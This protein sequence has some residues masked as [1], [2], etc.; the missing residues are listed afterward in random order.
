MVVVECPLETGIRTRDAFMK[1]ITGHQSNV[2]STAASK[3][4]KNASKWKCASEHTTCQSSSH[5]WKLRIPMQLL[6]RPTPTQQTI[7]QEYTVSPW[8]YWLIETDY[9]GLYVLRQ[10]YTERK[11][12]TISPI[13][14]IIDDIKREQLELGP[15]IVSFL[16]GYRPADTYMLLVRFSLP[17]DRRFL[18]QLHRGKKAYELVHVT[19]AIPNRNNWTQSTSRSREANHPPKPLGH[20]TLTVFVG[21]PQG[22]GEDMARGLASFVKGLTNWHGNP[23][24]WS[25]TG[26]W[27]ASLRYQHATAVTL[28][29]GQYASVAA[30]NYIHM[31][32][33]EDIVGQQSLDRMDQMLRQKITQDP[34][35]DAPFLRRLRAGKQ[36]G[37]DIMMAGVIQSINKEKQLLAEPTPIDINESDT[38]VFDDLHGNVEPVGSSPLPDTHTPAPPVDNN[39]QEEQ[40]T[41]PIEPDTTT[42]TPHKTKAKGY[43]GTP[44]NTP[45]MVSPLNKK[46]KPDSRSVDKALKP[47]PDKSAF[48]VVEPQ[49]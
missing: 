19:N 16:R 28:A 14:K 42:P 21:W 3:D 33:G 13:K 6:P 26:W 10:R 25:D 35:E 5:A 22:V 29:V 39:T 17:A 32:L 47:P 2:A 24:M 30:A 34:E 38:M 18:A 4:P 45:G 12:D 7:K 20:N 48:A 41:R 36:L 11:D 31:T 44:K 1:C 9:E 23:H 8:P 37:A 49:G 15:S 40:R 46:K 43:I 27:Y